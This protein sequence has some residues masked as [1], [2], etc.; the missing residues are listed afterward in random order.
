MHTGASW[1]RGPQLSDFPD[2]LSVSQRRHTHDGPVSASAHRSSYPPTGL[3]LRRYSQCAFSQLH[4]LFLTILFTATLVAGHVAI[5]PPTAGNPAVECEPF[6][7]TWTDGAPPYQIMVLFYP[8]DGL[9]ASTLAQFDGVMGHSQEWTVNAIANEALAFLILDANRYPNETQTFRV[10]QGLGASCLT[11]SSSE[12]TAPG[13]STFLPGS[14]SLPASLT[15][16]PS[17]SALGH[18]GSTSD[19]LPSPHKRKSPIGPVVGGVLGGLIVLVLIWWCIRRRSKTRLRIREGLLFNPSP[20]PIPPLDAEQVGEL[21]T[22]STLALDRP[23]PP[24]VIETQA[25]ML[26]KANA[27][28]SAVRVP[29]VTSPVGRSGSNSATGAPLQAVVARLALVEAALTARAEDLPPDYS[30]G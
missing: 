7:I 16:S 21:R 2:G 11:V 15:P 23:A 14:S 25:A 18:P 29:V 19:T 13:S 22:D 1:R 27:S 17:T 8:G 3:R 9:P 24:A 26:E 30:P 4:S 12:G 10:A 5:N 6:N 28:V 20:S